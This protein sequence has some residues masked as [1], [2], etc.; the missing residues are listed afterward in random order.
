MTVSSNAPWWVYVLIG[1]IAVFILFKFCGR[2]KN[3]RNAIIANLE[4]KHMQDS[5]K[6]AAD[7]IEYQNNIYNIKK[8]ITFK[9]D[10]INALG[11]QLNNIIKEN[12]QLIYKYKNNDY[13]KNVDPSAVLMPQEFVE[14]CKDC[15]AQLEK[16]TDSVEEYKHESDMIKI[17]WITQANLDSA[18]IEKLEHEKLRLNKDYNDMRAAAEINTKTLTSKRKLKI[19]IAGMLN[20]KFLPNAIGPGL[21]YEDKKD[22]DFGFKPMFGK[23]GQR[24]IIDVHV[25]LISF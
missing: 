18:R 16:T 17:L 23:D 6:M 4:N 22:R 9:S 19:G 2:S 8:Q 15:F 10:T 14:D 25:P 12:R 24:Y 5:V 21:I 13:I 3:D 7:S 20:D 11:M 1:G